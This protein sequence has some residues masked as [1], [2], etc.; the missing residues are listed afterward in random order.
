MAGKNCRAAFETRKR[1]PLKMDY[2]KIL[3]DSFN[4]VIKNKFLWFLGIFLGSGGFSNVFS[5]IPSSS[6]YNNFKQDGNIADITYANVKGVGK[7][8]GEKTSAYSADTF[9]WV[10]I[11]IIVLMLLLLMIYL[12]ITARGAATWSI[13]KLK[14]GNKYSL[15]EAW[16]MGHKY[17]WRRLSYALIVAAAIIVVLGVL[18]TPVAILAIYELIIPAVIIGIIFFLVLMAFFIYISLFLPY[19]ERVLFLE[20]KKPVEAIRSGAKL[21]N[22]NWANLLVMYLIIM[23]VGI[24]ITIG[25]C[26]ALLMSGSLIF[27]VAALI[28]LLNHIAAYVFGGLG[29]LAIFFVLIV[30]GGI[31]QAFNWSVMTLAYKEVADKGASTV[32]V[33][34]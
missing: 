12:T 7:V 2:L 29:A 26:L 1:N 34:P 33:R 17:F 18:V 8:L 10:S 3:K 22:K 15:A 32:T 9:V 14:E 30:L 27:G 11:A 23:G 4:L 6:D 5:N 19:S 16:K 25:I 13:V 20:N 21:F 31:L 24:G 28:Y